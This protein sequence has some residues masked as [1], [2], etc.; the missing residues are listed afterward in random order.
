MHI[1]AV[2]DMKILSTYE[3]NCFIQIICEKSFSPHLIYS[4]RRNVK[5]VKKR[6]LVYKIVSCSSTKFSAVVEKVLEKQC[7]YNGKIFN[8]YSIIFLS[9]EKSSLCTLRSN[10]SIYF[11]FDTCIGPRCAESFYSCILAL[12]CED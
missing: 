2:R 1:F 8:Y 9:M 10:T 11:K 5:L 4:V 3:I 7:W 6:Y 12:F